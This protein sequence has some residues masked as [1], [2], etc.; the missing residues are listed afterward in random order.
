M[1]NLK[2]L[3]FVNEELQEDGTSKWFL[4]WKRPMF[5]REES[6][7]IKEYDAHSLLDV[8][9]NNFQ[10]LSIGDLPQTIF[11]QSN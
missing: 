8:I 4:S 7:E 10:K 9:N 2:E 11:T 5:Q 3:L 6:V 1:T